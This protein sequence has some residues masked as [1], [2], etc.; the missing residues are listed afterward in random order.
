MEQARFDNIAKALGSQA[1]RRLTLSALLGGTLGA[2]GVADAGAAKSGKS[3]PACGECEKC[4]KGKCKPKPNGTAC[5]A[6]SGN[7]TCQTGV[8]ICPQGSTD[9]FGTCRS[10][11][12]DPAN[13][14]TCGKVCAALDSSC[15]AGRC[16]KPGG[17]TCFGLS[18]PTCCGH[19]APNGGPFVCSDLVL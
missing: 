16:C 9:C 2:F 7:A 1:T 3:K 5:T 8:C 15:A 4:K 12:T 11:Q 18:D 13:C 19:C 6:P 14:G 10:T 17:A